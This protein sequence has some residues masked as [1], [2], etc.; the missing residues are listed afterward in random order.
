MSYRVG[1]VTVFSGY[2]KLKSNVYDLYEN[3]VSRLQCTV[4]GPSFVVYDYLYLEDMPDGIPVIPYYD[5]FVINVSGRGCVLYSYALYDSQYELL[6]GGTDYTFAAPEAR[7]Q[8]ILIVFARWG[9]GRE[10]ERAEYTEIQY[11]CKIEVR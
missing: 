2:E 9:N 3:T 8:Y 10:D 7:G 4:D 5:N 6:A 11:F 1:N